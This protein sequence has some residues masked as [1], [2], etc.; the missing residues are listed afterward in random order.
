VNRAFEAVE[1]RRPLDEA[2]APIRTRA[3]WLV[4]GSYALVWVVFAVPYLTQEMHF[5]YGPFAQA[6]LSV[7]LVAGL[8]LSG[9]WIR[10]ARTHPADLTRAFAVMLS[11]PLVILIG[12]AGLCVP[13]L[14][15]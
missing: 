7:A 3:R 11:V 10:R 8:V 2:L 5:N 1:T 15:R 4:F 13:Y 6:I 9:V 12:V 14:P